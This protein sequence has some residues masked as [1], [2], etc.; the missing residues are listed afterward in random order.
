[1]LLNTNEY[2]ETLNDIKAQIKISQYRAVLGVNKEMI[3]LYWTIGK[4]IIA[5]TKYGAKF[6]QNLSKD[7]MLEFPEIKGFSVRNLKYMRQFAERYPD[8]QKV[9]E[10]LALLPWYNHITLMSKIKDPSV[11]QWYIQKN[12]ENGWNN[13]V[14]IHQKLIE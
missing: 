4:I 11:R 7:I 2:F 14:L 5:N 13:T 8:F 6:L 1:M 12:I 3:N 9:Q 10:P